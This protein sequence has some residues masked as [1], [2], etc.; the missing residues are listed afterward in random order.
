MRYNKYLSKQ[1]RRPIL[2]TVQTRRPR[3]N[4]GAGFFQGI[5]QSS[6][7]TNATSALGCPSLP[8]QERHRL[9]WPALKAVL[10]SASCLRCATR[11]VA[12]PTDGNKQEEQL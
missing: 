2:C 9:S 4:T 5:A 11:H 10:V 7:S 6:F 12:R 8:Q 3:W 1:A